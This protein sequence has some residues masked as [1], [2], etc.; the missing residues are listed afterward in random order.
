M[1]DN[2]LVIERL[3]KETKSFVYCPECGK[4]LYEM[5][6]SRDNIDMI[7]RRVLLN[8]VYGHCDFLEGHDPVLI[9][10]SDGKYIQAEENF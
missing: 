2:K 5:P 10:R 9:N 7:R 3:D 6:V 4:I 1:E 8:T